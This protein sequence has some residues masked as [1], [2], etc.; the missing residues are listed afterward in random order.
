ME[1]GIKKTYACD[2]KRFQY[3]KLS[4]YITIIGLLLKNV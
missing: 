4:K 3:V 1:I 2:L